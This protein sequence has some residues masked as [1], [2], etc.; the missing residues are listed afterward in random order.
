MQAL[1]VMARGGGW[2]RIA[3]PAAWLALERGRAVL[4]LP[5]LMAT[6]VLTYFS[7]RQEP[8]GWTG[9]ALLLPAGIGCRLARGG[10]LV[11]IVLAGMTAFALGLASAQL[12][13]WR[14]PPL[15]AL[16]SHAVTVTAIVRGIDP[17]PEGRRLLLEEAHLDGA[18]QPLVRLVRVRLRN[19]DPIVV[20]TGDTVRVRSLLRTPASPAYPG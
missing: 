17:L 19:G 20:A 15:L 8:P 14:A 7:L 1:L 9:V 11:R 13:T 16:P 12:A 6:G 18:A 4:W 10:S 2:A 5:V 3:L